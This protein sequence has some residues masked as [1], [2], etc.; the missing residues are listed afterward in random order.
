M[1]WRDLRAQIVASQLLSSLQGKWAAALDEESALLHK[2]QVLL[3]HDL[4]AAN[5]ELEQL[6]AGMADQ[7]LPASPTPSE[8]VA[9]PS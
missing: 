2:Q 7:G 9:S 8:Q 5:L 1:C 4:Q 3:A 6:R